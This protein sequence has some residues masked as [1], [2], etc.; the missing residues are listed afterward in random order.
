MDVL[1][2]LSDV[3]RQLYTEFLTDSQWTDTA[4]E[5][6]FRALTGDEN[7]TNNANTMSSTVVES[8]PRR[9]HPFQALQYLKLLCIHPSL[10]I[11]TD[12][13]AY[14]R[15]L[16]EE[17]AS[18]TKMLHLADLLVKSGVVLQDEISG[19]FDQLSA[20]LQARLVGEKVV[21]SANRTSG[22][23]DEQ[24]SASDNDNDEEDEEDK[25]EDVEEE[26]D[27][28]AVVPR[29]GVHSSSSTTN[30]ATVTVPTTKRRSARVAVLQACKRGKT[31]KIES[32][33]VPHEAAPSRVQSRSGTAY[34]HKCLIFST[35]RA[36]LDVIETVG[37]RAISLSFYFKTHLICYL[38]A[39]DCTEALFFFGQVCSLGWVRVT[40]PAWRPGSD[41]QRPFFR[42]AYT[43]SNEELLRSGP[44]PHWGGYSG[45]RGA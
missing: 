15:R 24:S 13:A 35:H 34:A 4:L 43:A 22:N 40:L 42:H 16:V 28:S 29:D 1:C 7:D 2:P 12:H 19:P 39:L 25:E 11:D 18:S 5:T 6:E 27:G 10:V 45:V 14:R 21:I 26:E 31:D 8:K 44:E 33:S 20:A 17:L 38:M 9:V 23:D 36:V 37:N 30:T 3:Q 32:V 41:V